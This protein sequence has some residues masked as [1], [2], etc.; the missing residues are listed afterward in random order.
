[1]SASTFKVL[2][3]NIS[4]SQAELF[5]GLFNWAL[6]LG[7]FTVFIGTIGSITMGTAREYFSNERLSANEVATER[8]K[9]E[10][11]T[12][13]EGA[14]K[15]NARAAEAD[16][17]L[18]KFRT[19]RTLT[20]EQQAVIGEKL[21]AFAGTRFDAAVIRSDPETYQLLGMIEAP[22]ATA[23]WTQVS[24]VGVEVL[25]RADKPD[26]GEWAATNVIIAVPHDLLPQLWGAA[27]SLAA[28]LTE[29]DIP[30]QAQDAQGMDVKNNDVLHLLIGRKM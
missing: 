6:I 22:L 5:Y 25:K 4:S 7:A 27:A 20:I 9:T 15:A 19:P 13:R 10:A 28:T 12:A 23:G 8:A 26:V 3:W 16:L 17:A 30:A 24:W 11:E 1:M 2:L 29:A 18:A 21:R 14:A